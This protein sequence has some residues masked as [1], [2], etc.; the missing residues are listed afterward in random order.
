MET[1]EGLINYREPKHGHT[2]IT[3]KVPF[4]NA[5]GD[6]VGVI[7]NFIIIPDEDD[8]LVEAT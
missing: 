3:N 7:D 8:G 4:R 5:E 1:G 6:V 2:I